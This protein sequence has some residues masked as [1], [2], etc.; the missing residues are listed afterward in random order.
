MNKDDRF[1]A[2][3]LMSKVQRLENFFREQPL[4]TNIKLSVPEGDVKA[5]IKFGAQKDL[6][7][8]SLFVKSNQN[9]VKF[10]KW[11]PNHI[12]EIDLNKKKDKALSVRVK[13]KK[14]TKFNGLTPDQIRIKKAN[15]EAEKRLIK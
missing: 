13:V 11:I 8:G 12:Y 1:I 3:F 6:S 2:R 5:A 4:V 15:A 10:Y 9:L 7:D 14:R